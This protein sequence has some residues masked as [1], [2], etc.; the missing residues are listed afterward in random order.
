MRSVYTRGHRYKINFSIF[1]IAEYACRPC[2][3]GPGLAE[4][5]GTESLR[6]LQMQTSEKTSL[7]L[8]P[9]ARTRILVEMAKKTSRIVVAHAR[10]KNRKIIEGEA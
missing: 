10:I 2:A 5:F 9:I 8:R 6:P 3:N 7:T 4:T 1:A